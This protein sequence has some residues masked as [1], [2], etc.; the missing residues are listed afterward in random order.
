MHEKAKTIWRLHVVGAIWFAV[1][2]GMTGALAGPADVLFAALGMNA[3]MSI[4][5]TLGIGL[6]AGSLAAELTWVRL[7]ARAEL[8]VSRKAARPCHRECSTAYPS[9][10][11]RRVRGGR[12]MRSSFQP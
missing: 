11:S 4:L 6:A 8:A 3:M 2:L 5:L 9:S 7:Q 12:P 1:T 10:R